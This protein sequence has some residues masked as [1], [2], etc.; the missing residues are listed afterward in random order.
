[1]RRQAPT[2][3]ALRTPLDYIV[4]TR[5]AVRVLRVLHATQVPLSQAELARRAELHARGLPAI[6][7]GLEAAGMVSY[8]GRGRTRQV[9]LYHLHPLI[10]PL[11]QL[12]QSEASRWH[13]VQQRLREVVHSESA[14]LIAAWIEGRVSMG[15]DRFSDPI[16]VG[17]LSEA[18]LPAAVQENLRRQ[19]NGLQSQQHVVI[20]LHFH[21]RAD[22]V[23]LSPARR[24]G[25]EHA[26]LLYGPAPLDIP[27]TVAKSGSG[28]PG[29]A[30]SRRPARS[31]TLSRPREIAEVVAGKLLRDPELINR[32][33]EFV[34]RRLALAGDAERLTLLEWKGLL[35]SL[36]GGQIAAVLRED[37]ARADALRQSLPFVGVLT[38]AERAQVFGPVNTA[39]T[40]S[41]SRVSRT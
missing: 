40:G 1:M 24:S 13:A 41:S 11:R 37:S 31:S 14:R 4:G 34:D 28:K 36:T 32:A 3:S 9:Q 33:R 39:R 2:S 29:A 7:D 20:A 6:L 35:D 10:Q 26:I 21:H 16:D 22:F 12:F 5:G 17:I 30:R 38:N 25:L 23:R 19:S 15:Q 18:P 8:A 27:G